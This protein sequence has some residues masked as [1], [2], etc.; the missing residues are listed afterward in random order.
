MIKHNNYNPVARSVK[1]A[2]AASLCISAGVTVAQEQPASTTAKEKAGE[3]I[4]VVGTRAAPRSI[5]DSP[6][7]IDIISGEELNKNGNSDMLNLIS[8][9]VPSL[10]VHTQPISDTGSLIRPINLRG[11]SSDST[12]VLLNGKRRHR[13]SVKIGR[14]SCRE[15][16]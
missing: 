5:G 10:N 11:L 12:L 6:V 9:T 16:V 8:T 1:F 2:L 4:A 13:A 3:K 14:A 15:R 7:P